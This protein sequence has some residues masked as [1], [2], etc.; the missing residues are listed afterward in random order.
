M[1][2]QHWPTDERQR[3]TQRK[4]GPDLQDSDFWSWPHLDHGSL[5]RATLTSKADGRLQWSIVADTTHRR[6]IAP[7]GP[8]TRTFPETR[9][10]EINV[11]EHSVRKRSEGG[12]QY[13]RTYFPDTDFPG[14]LVQDELTAAPAGVDP[15]DPLMGNLLELLPFRHSNDGYDVLFPM[16]SLGR[17]LNVSSLSPSPSGGFIFRASGIPSFI[18]ET[19]ILHLSGSTSSSK[20]V[21]L[22][23]TIALARTYTSISLI[24]LSSSEDTSLQVTRD[25]ELT[26]SD[27][28]DIPI[29]DSRIL[30]AGPD[31]ISV[32]RLGHV[33]KSNVYTAGKATQVNPADNFWQLGATSNRDGCFL[34]SSTCVKYLDFR[35][36]LVTYP[37]GQDNLSRVTTSSDIIWLD[38]RFPKKPVLSF[39]HHRSYDRTLKTLTVQLGFGPLVLLTSRKNGL[40][41]VYDVSRG[42]DN[43]VHCNSPPTCLSW[44]RPLY[45]AHT[46]HTAVATPCMSKMS[47]L[48]LTHQGSIYQQDIHITTGNQTQAFKEGNRVVREWDADVEKLDRQSRDLRPDPGPVGGRHFTEVNF[49]GVYERIFSLRDDGSGEAFRDTLAQLPGFWQQMEEPLEIMLTTWIVSPFDLIAYEKSKV[50]ANFFTGCTANGNSAFQAVARGDI[51]IKEL[52]SLAPWSYNILETMHRLPYDISEDWST[53]REHL[54]KLQLESDREGAGNSLR[55]Q[56]E[57]QEQLVVDLALSC[58]VFSP[59]PITKPH[60]TEI[61]FGTISEENRRTGVTDEPPDVEFSFFHP[62]RKIGAN[63]YVA[64]EKT[65]PALTE[66]DTKVSCPMGVRLLLAEWEVGSDVKN[67]TYRDPHYALPPPT[68]SMVVPSQH[69]PTVVATGTRPQWEVTG[70]QVAHAAK[71]SYSQETTSYPKLDTFSQDPIQTST[72]V[73]S[74]PYGGRL[75]VGKRPTKKRIGGSSSWFLSKSQNP[76]LHHRPA[77]SHRRRVSHETGIC[78]WSSEEGSMD[79]VSSTPQNPWFD[80][81]AFND[82]LRRNKSVVCALSASYISSVRRLDSL[83]SRLQTTKTR[84]SLLKLA[85]LVYREE[86]LIGFYRGLWIPLVTISFV[87]AS[88][89]IYSDTKEYCRRKNYFSG[90]S[91]YDAAFAGGISGALSGSLISFGS[92]LRRPCPIGL[93][94]VRRQLEYSI[95]ATK[96][97]QLIKP[98]NTI[99]AVRDIVRMHGVSGLYLGF[100]LHFLRDTSGTALYFFE[101]DA[102]RHLLGRERSGEQ[103]PTPQWLP[104]PNSLIPFVCGSFAG[105]TSWA[106]IYPLDVVKTKVQQRALAN[107]PPRGVW[108]TFHRLVRG[109]DPKDPK[110]VLAGI[111]RIYRGLGVSA[112]RSITTHG[113]LW[114]FF[115]F[116]SQYIDGLS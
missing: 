63:H 84:I 110:P 48:R 3:T 51:P 65:S 46:G 30:G 93:Q 57:A 47:F 85:G 73:L 116:T 107:T 58:D 69:P 31:I 14:D 94:K 99:E 15:S 21:P 101:Y 34:T 10:P 98:P 86:G 28:G 39:K 24:K 82:T 70:T 81:A 22:P 42:T 9:P 50:P 33:Y 91:M 41:T 62:I 74:G 61:G 95:A 49:R 12:L 20:S 100:R 1:D 40:V 109:P 64:A 52:A 103:G 88:F 27:T 102:M 4:G 71:Q 112:V 44:D 96:G 77:S 53:F 106:L 26:R 56:T 108:E 67:Y 72:Q 32:N 43:L 80:N 55:L 97:I 75:M 104:I 60:P 79:G 115:D 45:T 83:K 16:G 54:K 2:S 114:T 5:G 19:P 36:G 111:A 37:P 29:V 6:T 11:C 66:D 68:Q 87:P 90:D 35:D 18:F 113:L 7:I 13:L 105:V 59:R 89:T 17:E 25:I 78:G 23:Y 76:R 38:D 8:S 92:A